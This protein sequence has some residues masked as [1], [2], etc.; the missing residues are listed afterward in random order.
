MCS[1]PG[2]SPIVAPNPPLL[3]ALIETVI[4]AIGSRFI[5]AVR[6]QPEPMLVTG[7]EPV[8]LF[9]NQRFEHGDSCARLLADREDPIRLW[10]DRAVLLKHVDEILG[11][12]PGSRLRLIRIRCCSWSIRT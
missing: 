11:S 1:R 5:V 4:A 10:D 7:S 3:L 8:V 6:R 12:S 2:V 9:Q